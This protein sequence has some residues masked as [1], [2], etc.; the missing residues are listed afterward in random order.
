MYKGRQR[1][2]GEGGAGKIPFL[3]APKSTRGALSPS[4]VH[5]FT[6]EGVQSL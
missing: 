4:K 1:N 6:H 5:L 2:N 3:A